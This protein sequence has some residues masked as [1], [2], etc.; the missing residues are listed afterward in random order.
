[1]AFLASV[2]G[3]INVARR[4][5]ISEFSHITQPGKT[6]LGTIDWCVTIANSYILFNNHC[7]P[8]LS[9]REREGGRRADSKAPF[10]LR[11]SY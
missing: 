3:A 11:V 1:M 10:S 7:T 2:K 9:A 8:S 6:F 4:V 5:E